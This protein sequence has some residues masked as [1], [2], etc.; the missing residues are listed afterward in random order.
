LSFLAAYRAP[1]TYSPAPTRFT[2]GSCSRV[3]VYC[4]INSIAPFDKKTDDK[5]N[6][7]SKSGETYLTVSYDR[8]APVLVEAIKELNQKNIALTKENDELKDKSEG[9]DYIDVECDLF[10]N[11]VNQPKI[12]FLS[13]DTEGNELK[14]LQSIDFDKFDINVLMVMY[15]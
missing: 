12:D 13:I 4:I 11:I 8:L 1:Y 10:E 9:F 15:S 7:S 3:N 5:G 6:E 2:A 14:I